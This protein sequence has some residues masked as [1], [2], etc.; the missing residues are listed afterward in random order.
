LIQQ[1]S[2]STVPSDA[3]LCARLC[4]GHERFRA[5]L[6]QHLLDGT[7]VFSPRRRK[8]VQKVLSLRRQRLLRKA[9]PSPEL[10]AIRESYQQGSI[11][12]AQAKA[13][14]LAH[15]TALGART[16]RSR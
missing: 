16:L 14:A 12:K 10:A 4:R 3:E 11:S 15:Y 5:R 6:E 13:M 7:P 9:G 1:L 2:A 8:I